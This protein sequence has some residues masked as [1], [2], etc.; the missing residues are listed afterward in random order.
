MRI[1]LPFFFSLAILAL[2]TTAQ[3]TDAYLTWASSKWG[4][5][6]VGSSAAKNTTWG[7]NA[8]PDKDGLPNL[9]EYTADTDPTRPNPASDC[10][11]FILPA[12][13][14]PSSRYP[15]LYA[16]QRTDD[17]DLRVTCQK[18]SNLHSWLPEAPGNFTQP[19]PPNLYVHTQET[20]TFMRGLRQVRYIDLQS[21]AS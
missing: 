10:F 1:P 15:Q 3:A 7:E 16:W 6:A 11:E 14:A 21:M 17:P 4:V 19:A 13:G 18:S 12:T 9:I 8:D 2:H 20:G 5:T